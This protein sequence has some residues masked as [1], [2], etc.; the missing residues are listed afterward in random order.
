MLFMFKLQHLLV[1]AIFNTM[2]ILNNEIHDYFTRQC[3]D[4]HLPKWRLEVRRRSICVQGPLIWNELA[5]KF[6]IDCTIPTFK[7]HVKRY[8]L[9]NEVQI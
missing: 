4:Y 9:E 1:P 7:F 2:F 5:N 8:L 6:A 3:C